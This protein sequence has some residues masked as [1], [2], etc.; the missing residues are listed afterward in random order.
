MKKR[1]CFFLLVLI[2]SSGKAQCPLIYDYLGT[3]TT[4]PRFISCNGSSYALNLVSSSNWG[5]YTINWGDA[6]PVT[7]GG[8]YLANSV[9]GHT[10]AATT[11][12]YAITLMIPSQNCTTTGFVAVEQPVFAGII[13]A[14][15]V[16]LACAPKTLTFTNV[17]TFT[18]ATT[19]YT[20]NFGDGSPLEVHSYT[21]SAQSVTH[22]YLKG[23]VSC[24]TQVILLA[25]NFCT[26]GAPTQGQVNPLYVFDTDVA[27]VTAD[28]IVRCWPDNTFSFQNTTARNCVPQGN[29]FQR[30]ERWN[31]GNYW[32][33]GGDSIVG[34]NPWPPSSSRIV[35]YPGIG[36][37]SVTLIDSNLCGIDVTNIVVSIVSPPTASLIAPTGN[38]CQNTPVT[39]TNASTPGR[40]YLWNFG[41]GGGFQNLG[42]GNKSNSYSVPGTYTVKLVCQ[43]S[44]GGTSCSDTS[45]AI[46]NILPS[47]VSNFSVNPSTGCNTIIGAVFSD[48]STSA[49]TWNW[50]FGNGNISTSSSP[51]PQNYLVPGTFVATLVVTGTTTCSHTFTSAL[52]VR[53]KPLPNFVQLSACVGSPV[54]FTNT[55]T[56]TGGTNSITTYVWNF[57]D[58][59]ATSNSVNPIH[60]YT[61]PATYTVKLVALSA[62]CTDS[63]SLPI[64]LNIKPTANFIPTPTLGCPPLAVSFS[65][66]TINGN[67]S[68]WKYETAGS[69]TSSVT[70]PTYNFSN[71][72]L[73]FVNYTVTLISTTGIGCA[74]SIKKVISV[75][76]KPVANFTSNV[77]AGCSPFLA[78]FTNTSLGGFTYSWTLGD[79]S[80]SIQQNPTHTYTNNSLF[81]QTVTVTM[82]VTNSVSCTDLISKSLIIYAKPN[83][84]FTMLPS[85]GCHPL[86][87]TFPAVPGVASYTWTHG[88]GSPQLITINAPHTHT[89]LNTGL[90]NISF[91][92][93]LIAGN[94]SG[95]IDSAKAAVVVFPKPTAGIAITPTA[96]CSPFASVHNGTSSTAGSGFYWKYGDGS[97]LNTGTANSVS[98]TYMNASN[99]V[100]QPYTTFLVVTSP[101]GCKDSV[102]APLTVYFKPESKFILDTPKCVSRTI[103]FNNLSIGTFSQT[104]NFGDGT[105]PVNLLN[106]SHNYSN[107]SINN[108]TYTVQLIGSSIYNCLDTALGFPKVY[109]KP[110]ANFS[111]IPSN[112]CA[113]LNAGLNFS[114]AFA[115]TY[116]WKYGDGGTSTLQS[117]SHTYNNISNAIN[118]GYNATLLAFNNNG[119]KD[120]VTK[121]LLVYYKPFADFTLDTPA[122]TPK[123]IKFIN[124]SEG[125]NSFN[126]DF[127]NGQSSTAT[128]TVSQ[129]YVNN[130][131]TTVAYVTSLIARTP[132]NCTDT[133]LVKFFVYPKPEFLISSA[134]DTGCTPLRVNFAKIAGAVHYQWTFE[135]GSYSS[136]DQ[137]EN[138]FVNSGTSTRTYTVQ[139]IA[140]DVHQCGDTSFK[141]IKVH[142][143]P[144]AK[145]AASPLSV[146]IPNDP[147]KCFNLSIG[148]T[149]F[150][151]DFGDGGSSKEKEPTY[152][153]TK[154]GEFEIYLIAYNNY[155]CRDTAFLPEKVLALNET[156][157]EFPN[158]FTPNLAGS[159][160]SLYDPE[161]RSNDIFHPNVR[162]ADQYEL[163][164]YSRWGELLFET[165][166]PKE[167]WDGYYKG[168]L[169]VQDVYVWKVVVTFL[170]GKR[171]VKTGDVLLSR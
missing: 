151:W 156:T 117:T 148:A 57:D 26:F 104:W 153:Y 53:P 17:S 125:A 61:A 89:F 37:Y 101:N 38:L 1:L 30:Q 99:S 98:H 122:C 120:S 29:T 63:I 111:V 70:N 146:Y 113:P 105:P 166:N 97:V 128:A 137:V 31:F 92:V 27:A 147:T 5:A 106:P 52:V 41:N 115:H 10:Y 141:V 133:A 49:V 84:T 139:L 68:L 69:A 158:A 94:V 96:G 121:P 13:V 28:R 39:F 124:N 48:L 157:L 108:L 18:S 60:T 3:P 11:A 138:I 23:T 163:S 171:V 110:I 45:I 58:G 85:S 4:T 56:P 127:G 150:L 159:P 102:Y 123:V 74:D 79:G 78:T 140:D 119:C 100:N 168:V 152:F 66:T 86:L 25:K 167:G 169:C 135:A 154:P 82:Q 20:W 165:K 87:V 77:N 42:S 33:M 162:G 103:N 80:T 136:K 155:G 73:N 14:G 9:I 21:N 22:T 8:S 134:P 64:L 7:N 76:P 50:N 35:A 36:T 44:G 143:K 114:G 107:T 93:S 67:S 59:S 32:G 118:Q 126:W 112:G 43:V 170:D 160:G 83:V 91:T 19:S 145:F 75:R 15:G 109:A 90:S 71:T 72:T 40:S 12:T 81:Q 88:D 47:P 55:S 131:A 130:S 95:C 144:T 142:P 62:F 2:S 65:N 51:P 34:W 149:S 6:S 54:N 116:F 164:I 161:D 16:A 129:K 46:I 132:N 24:Q